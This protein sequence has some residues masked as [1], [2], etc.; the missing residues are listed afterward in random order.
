MNKLIIANWKMNIL[1]SESVKFVKEIEKINTDNQIIILAPYIDLPYLRSDK[2]IF[3]SQNVHQKNK[4]SYTGEI[5]PLMLKDININYCL[6]GHLERREYF[7]ENTSL[8]ELKVRNSINNGLKVILCVNS[9]KTLMEIIVGVKNLED[10]I[11]AFEP[12]D[13][14]GGSKIVSTDKIIEFVKGVKELTNNR[15]KVVYGGG[16]NINNI[17]SLK[18]IEE[19]DGIMVGS[20]S[21]NLDRFKEIIKNY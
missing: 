2:L 5:S 6:I 18:Q 14:I 7:K 15:C 20:N 12:D 1:P 16:I 3:G 21:I 4:G 9:I 10:L 19:L 11:V 8:I 13:Y 17:N